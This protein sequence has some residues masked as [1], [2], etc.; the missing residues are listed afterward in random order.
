MTPANTS[1]RSFIMRW[2]ETGSGLVIA[3]LFWFLICVIAIV[4]TAQSEKRW[5]TL[6]AALAM[7]SQAFFAAAVWKLSRNQFAY[8]KQVS[9]RQH[10]IDMYPLRKVA[11]D[12]L[13]E[14]GVL[15]IPAR[16]ITEDTVEAFRYCHL[17]INKLFSETTD[18]LAF[19]LYQVVEQAHR[20]LRPVEPVYDDGGSI[21]VP[22]DTGMTDD[23]Y[24]CLD[25]AFNLYTD[26]Q[27]AIADEMRIR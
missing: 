11:V 18:D 27:N 3:I 10:K 6:I 9:E 8:T 7:G 12:R 1:F 14:V 17:E 16:P 5:D 15:I 21:V 23:A 24:A 4:A 25:D 19:E 13:E 2:W 26:L 22:G 20:Y